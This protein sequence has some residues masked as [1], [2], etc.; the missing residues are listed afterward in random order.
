MFL[1]CCYPCISKLVLLCIKIVLILIVAISQLLQNIYLRMSFSANQ[2]WRSRANY[3]QVSH[4]P[5]AGIYHDQTSSQSTTRHVRNSTY[6]SQDPIMIKRVLRARRHLF[7]MLQMTI[8]NAPFALPTRKTWSLA[9][10]IRHVVSADKLFSCARF[11]ENQSIL[12]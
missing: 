1:C 3:R 10:A 12:E 11:V 8:W 6:D 4:V 2:L 7:Q 9:V 5:V